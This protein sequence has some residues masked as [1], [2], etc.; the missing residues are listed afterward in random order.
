VELAISELDGLIQGKKCD[1]TAPEHAAGSILALSE[2]PIRE[3]M[4]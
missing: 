1:S 2:R 3:I 4:G